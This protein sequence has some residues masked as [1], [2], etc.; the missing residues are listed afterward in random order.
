VRYTSALLV[1]SGVLG[2]TVVREVPCFF[3]AIEKEGLQGGK[4]D[5]NEVGQLSTSTPLES[6]KSLNSSGGD[7]DKAFYDKV[8]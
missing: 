8:F 3:K 7:T 6:N 2:S 1:D 4:G 5:K